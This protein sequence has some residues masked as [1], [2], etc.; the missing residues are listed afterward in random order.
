[1]RSA[2]TIAA[3]LAFAVLGS[4]ALAFDI[5]NGGGA[6]GNGSA[7]LATD[8]EA[9]AG[10]SLDMDL[11]AQL[12]LPDDKTKS[13]TETKSGLQFGGGVFSGSGSMNSS[14][15]SYDERPWVAPRVPAGRD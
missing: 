12:G 14:T 3:L 10:V 2:A 11:R 5:Q 7:N 1:M 9:S 8:P 4:P 6:S 13:T 15:M